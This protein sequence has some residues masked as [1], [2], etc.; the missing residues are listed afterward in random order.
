MY[1]YR[2]QNH[3]IEHLKNILEYKIPDDIIASIQAELKRTRSQP[4]NADQ[5]YM[6]L[7]RLGK[8]KY[9]KYSEKILRFIQGKPPTIP[10]SDDQQNMMIK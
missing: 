4:I 7:K 2:R 8:P 10:I 9:Y 1:T 3:F 6:I 5:I